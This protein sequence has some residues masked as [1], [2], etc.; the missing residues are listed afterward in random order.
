MLVDHNSVEYK[1]KI[2]HAWKRKGRIERAIAFYQ[3]V[4]QLEPNNLLAHQ[5]IGNLLIKQDQKDAALDYYEKALAIDFDR[6]DL[7]TYYELLGL[8]SVRK[9]KEAAI[10]TTYLPSLGNNHLPNNPLGKINLANQAQFKCHRSGWNFALDALAPLH[11][12]QGI[13]FD[14]FLEKTFRWQCLTDDVRSS[15]VLAK[16]QQDGVYEDLA[17]SLEKKIIPYQTPWVGFLHN[18][19][20]IPN[21]LSSGN[22]PQE[23]F[24]R[25]VWQ[26]SL[27]NCV[28]LFALSE[29]HARWL[30]EQTNKPVS[31][32]I[33][34]TEIPERQFDFNRFIA[35]PQKKIIQVGWWLRRL[36]SIFQLP[37]SQNNALGYQKIMLVPQFSLHSEIFLDGLIEQQLEQEGVSKEAIYWQNTQKVSHLSNDKYDEILAA[38]IVFIDLYDASANNAIIECIARATPILVNP[39]PAVVEYL[40]KDYP[41][42]FNSLAEAAAKAMDT[43]LIWNT[44][45]YLKNCFTRDKLSPEYFL[46]TFKESEVYQA[47]NS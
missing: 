13:L 41:M 45:N 9:E 25:D 23:L 40:G 21:W 8:S 46:K 1:L 24:I 33:F 29:Y 22:S 38:N 32:L 11:N 37:I 3:E 27:E 10:N 14:G 16:M 19:Q 7:S 47:I 36:F 34:A 39:L 43:D 4:L 17:T 2:A 44:H 26:Q 15:L 12:E 18:P 31:A 35:N 5:Y 30:R 28:G 42:Y 20:R 6:V